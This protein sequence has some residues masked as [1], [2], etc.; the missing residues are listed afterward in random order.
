MIQR[1][2][3]WSGAVHWNT[4]NVTEF[5]KMFHYGGTSAQLPVN[6]ATAW[7]WTNATKASIFSCPKYGVPRWAEQIEWGP[8]LTDLSGS[9]GDCYIDE[10]LDFCQDGQGDLDLRGWCVTNITS[11]PN[12]FFVSTANVHNSIFNNMVYPLW[13]TCAEKIEDFTFP[14]NKI[15]IDMRIH[16]DKSGEEG[17][18]RG[19]YYEGIE[20]AYPVIDVSGQAYVLPKLASISSPFNAP[21]ADCPDGYI[22]VGNPSNFEFGSNSN[23]NFNLEVTFTENCNTSQWVHT[24]GSKSIFGNFKNVIGG[25]EYIDVSNFTTLNY[26]FP[27]RVPAKIKND[28]YEAAWPWEGCANWNTSKVTSMKYALKRCTPDIPK[29][30]W[31]FTAVVDASYMFSTNYGTPKWVEDIQ[32]GPNLTEL[33][34]FGNGFGSNQPSGGASVDNWWIG[35]ER[36]LDLS[37]WDVRNFSSTPSGF[38]STN[39]FEEYGA[40]ATWTIEPNWGTTGS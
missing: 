40:I 7:D 33:R 34:L 30:N 12:N 8:N 2:V 14:A 39:P 27:N 36:P 20:D 31:D 18:D 23:N 6:L 37:K 35:Q 26:L 9:G 5:T 10:E 38:M 24:D 29:M 19:F 4:S 28:H 11:R 32:W 3:D 13:G 16:G 22:F 15:I 21:V 25:F 1:H 17:K